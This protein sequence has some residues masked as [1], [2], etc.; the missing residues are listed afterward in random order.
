MTIIDR[1]PLDIENIIN[2]IK[3]NKAYVV[4]PAILGFRY[5]AEILRGVISAPREKFLELERLVNLKEE[6]AASHILF[7]LNHLFFAK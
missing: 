4:V 7:K 6:T 2:E 1:Y 5:S 3:S